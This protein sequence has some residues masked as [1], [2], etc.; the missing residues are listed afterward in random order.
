MRTQLN[1][2]IVADDDAEL[3]R[4]FDY[5]VVSPADVR[6]AVKDNPEG[7]TLTIEINSP[8][9]SMF[10]GYEI[11]SVLK[12]C[13]CPT[14]AEVQSM[15][16]SAAS[17]A[18]LGADRVEASPVAQVM[19]HLPMMGTQGDRDE[20]ARSVAALDSFK[21]SILNAYELK[22][23]GKKTRQELS[24]MME[25]ETWLSVQDSVSA[26]LVD[27]VLYDEGGVIAS[28]VVNCVGASIRTL[29]NMGGL[30]MAA[31]LRARKDATPNDMTH[32]AEPVNNGEEAD[33]LRAELDLLK[34]K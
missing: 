31:E 5:T 15:A 30:P 6:Q 9:G 20:H 10:A 23:N 25:A 22:C 34:M 17:T 12:A 18:M 29:A 3:Y 2:F 26:G 13:S 1:G 32:P 14:V 21:E 4:W 8:G 16:A 27:G 11:Y 28:Q 24:A 33:R 19:I 7:E